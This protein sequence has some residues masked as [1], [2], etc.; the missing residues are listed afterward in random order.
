VYNSV[1]V[2]LASLLKRNDARQFATDGTPLTYLTLQ[3]TYALWPAAHFSHSI[4]F[5]VTAAA[6]LRN[7][8]LPVALWSIRHSA[9]G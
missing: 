6:A 3:R 4:C 9:S 1:I 8:D 7:I 5:C 2:A